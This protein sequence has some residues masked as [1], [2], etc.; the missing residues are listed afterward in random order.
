LPKLFRLVSK[1]AL[2]E[3]VFK[4]ETINTPSMLAVEDAIFALEWAKGLGGLPGLIARSDANA[5]ALDEIVRTRDW[6]GHL[7]ADPASRS[8]TSVCLTVAGA[9]AALIKAMAS[10][11]EAEGAAYDIASYR[12]AP[13]GLRIWCGATVDTADIVALG[14][15]LDWAYAAAKAA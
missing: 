15:W 9:D 7:A 14:P 1:G 10:L 13:P 5:A 2:A 4:G 8:K 11:L 3:G 6:L 12:D